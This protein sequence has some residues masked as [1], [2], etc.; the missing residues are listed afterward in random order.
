MSLSNKKLI[1]TFLNIQENILK[2][3]SLNKTKNQ[4]NNHLKSTL[5]T[6]VAQLQ[7]MSVN[8]KAACN[9]IEKMD[10]KNRTDAVVYML[11]KAMSKSAPLHTKIKVLDW[12]KQNKF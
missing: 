7:Y 8:K 3:L 2:Q 4:T 6:N 11:T 10:K 1:K 9:S 5:K 12:L